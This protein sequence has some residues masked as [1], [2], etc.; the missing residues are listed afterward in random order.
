MRRLISRARVRLRP[1]ADT[2]ADQLRYNIA[3][4]DRW[5][6]RSSVAVDLW[7]QHDHRWQEQDS[8]LRVT[9]LGAGNERLRLLLRER[10]AYNVEYRPY[11]LHPQLTTTTRLDARSA[12]P[13]HAADLT[14]ALGLLEYIR[15]ENDIVD[16]LRKHSKFAIVSYVGMSPSH[17]PLDRRRA[18]GWVRHQT[19]DEFV[20][21]FAMAGFQV[22]ATGEADGGLTSIHL[23]GQP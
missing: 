18:H 19:L 14:F 7:T 12:L 16:R 23:F 17:I 1:S 13:A 2:V 8:T 9:D 22:L 21:L 5:E 15:R 11:D 3:N 6:E 20:A 4:Q 10:L